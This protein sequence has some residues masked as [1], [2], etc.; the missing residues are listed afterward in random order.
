MTI[1]EFSNIDTTQ[2]MCLVSAPVRCHTPLFIERLKTTIEKNNLA[3]MVGMPIE[4]STALVK[5]KNWQLNQSTM[6][7]TKSKITR[8]G[9]HNWDYWKVDTT[10]TNGEKGYQIHWSDD[11]EC[12]A[13]HVYTKE[14]ADLIASAPLLIETLKHIQTI[15]ML[16]TDTVDLINKAIEVSKGNQY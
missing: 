1:P 5:L 13:D 16:D 6:S 3:C 14:D 15:G 2:Q 12:V 9:T 11:G 4:L 8:I 7:C 10:E